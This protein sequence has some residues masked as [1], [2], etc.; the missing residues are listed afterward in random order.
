MDNLKRFIASRIYE[1]LARESWAGSE[2]PE[3]VRE[4]SVTHTDSLNCQVKVKTEGAASRYFNVRVSE[5]M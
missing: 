4:I 3:N 2:V 5:M 1:L